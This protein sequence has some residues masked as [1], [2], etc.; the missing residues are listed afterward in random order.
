MWQ[1]SVISQSIKLKKMEII[2]RICNGGGA[3]V[4]DDDAILL[5]KYC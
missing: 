5:Q 1:M 2:P 3:D 4:V